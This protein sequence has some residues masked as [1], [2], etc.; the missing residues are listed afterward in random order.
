LNLCARPSSVI[1]GPSRVIPGLSK[2]GRFWT[3]NGATDCN[4]NAPSGAHV[5]LGSPQ[6]PRAAV[7]IP[8]LERG[9]QF[10]PVRTAFVCD[11]WSIHR[12]IP[13]LAK[14]G[15]FWT[16]SGAIDCNRNAPYGAH[17][18]LG[19]PQMH[20]TAVYI[21]FL[22]RG[23]QF[24]LVRTDFVCDRWSIHR[25]IPGLPKRGRCWTL[26]GATDCNT[27]ALYGAHVALGSPR[28]HLTAVCIPFLQ[29]GK[30]FEPVR[31]A[32]VCDRWSIHRVIPGLPKRGRFWTLNGATDC[33]TN[34]P[35]GAHV[36]FGT[37][38]MHL[39][40]V[41]IP[42]LERGKQFWTCAHGLRL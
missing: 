1:D 18:A 23:N 30:Q 15:R 22:E 24:E 28:M 14:R 37:P 29:R 42:F 21:P 35:C 6:E 25:V 41:C 2:R 16:L 39:T 13:G 27:N 32:F 12:V 5:A 31:T 17:V 8:F 34:A 20:L 36:A 7:C 19:R 10:E 4:T 3:L 38:Q 33:N 40:A 11:R 9:K 26:N